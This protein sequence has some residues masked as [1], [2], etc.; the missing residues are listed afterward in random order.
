MLS[1]I[2]FGGIGVAQPPAAGATVQDGYLSSINIDTFGVSWPS[3]AEMIQMRL[4]EPLIPEESEPLPPL[5]SA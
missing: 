3:D 5:P 1:L 2:V 4:I